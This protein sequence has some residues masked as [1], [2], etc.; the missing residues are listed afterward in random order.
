MWSCEGRGVSGTSRVSWSVEIDLWN[1]G[2]TYVAGIDEAGRGALAGP[3]VA[4]AVV[5]PP[6]LTIENVDDSKRLSPQTREAMYHEI[7]RVAI[8]VGVGYADAS[9]IDRVNIRQGTLL[10]MQAAIQELPCEPDFLLVDGLDRLP[11][12][13]L[14]RQYVRGD[15]TI[16]SIAAASIIAKV[17]RDRLMIALDGRCPGYGFAQHKGYGTMVHLR[18][19]QTL[20][21]SQ[22]HRL[23]FRGVVPT[24]S[25]HG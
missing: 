18:A 17:S 15:Q 8:G 4:A 19:I 14:Q 25:Y 11:A 6:G 23:T 16:G 22:M 2:R 9:T 13:Q 5:L 7:L 21:P 1:Q 10:A 3:V 20:G 12:S 24:T